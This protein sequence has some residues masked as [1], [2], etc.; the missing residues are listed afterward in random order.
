MAAKLQLPTPEEALINKRSHVYDELSRTLTDGVQA[1]E[2]VPFLVKETL[3]LEAWKERRTP[4]GRMLPP[5]TLYGFVH[6]RLPDGL[7]TTFATIE[8]LIKDDAEA[9]AMW[10]EATRGKQGERT[11]LVD[12]VHD[13]PAKPDGNSRE[14]ALRRLNKLER[15]GD[16]RAVE[17]KRAVVA[18]EKSAHRALIDLGPRREDDD[19][20]D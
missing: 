18:G 8:K 11:D 14:A 9:L 16:E 4:N 17:A 2:M 12:N 19:R 10:T 20:S 15:E 6:D 3:R 1:H 5:G 13:V 7:A